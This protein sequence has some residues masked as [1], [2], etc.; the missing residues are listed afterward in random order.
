MN[1][2]G[3]SKFTIG[4]AAAH[5]GEFR[6]LPA[7]SSATD[8]R[9]VH[10]D[11]YVQIYENQNVFPRAFMVYNIHNVSTPAAALQLLADPML[12][13]KQTA[14]VENLPA[15]LE[16]VIKRNDPGMQSVPGI[17][18]LI[19]SGELDVEADTKAPGLLVV[20]DQYYPG[21]QAIVDGKPAA[22]FAVDESF[23]G[24]FLNCGKSHGKI[25]IPTPLFYCGWCR[26]R[27]FAADSRYLPD[28]QRT[29][30]TE[31]TPGFHGQRPAAKRWR[32]VVTTR[33]SL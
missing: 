24:V 7:A 27:C 9:L 23:R 17:A 10:T 30:P 15:N 21:W 13:L 26:K 32:L 16:T 14:V 19:S 6:P 8:Y 25:H 12:D 31:A 28:T 4:M 33:P 5:W 2:P 3:E 1:G 11:K 22:I 29:P 20:S 18:K